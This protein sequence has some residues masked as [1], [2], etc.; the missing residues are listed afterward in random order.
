MPIESTADAVY[1]VICGCCIVSSCRHPAFIDACSYRFCVKFG[2]L[3][4][5]GSHQVWFLA[6]WP[7][8]MDLFKLRSVEGDVDAGQL[9]ASAISYDCCSEF[10]LDHA[11]A[12]S[13][14]LRVVF[15]FVI[16]YLQYKSVSLY[17]VTCPTIV[18]L[19]G[20]PSCNHGEASGFLTNFCFFV[21][22]L[23][24]ASL[25]LLLDR[26]AACICPKLS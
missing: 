1:S 17:V 25:T 6:Q 9:Y 5:L 26:V 2:S 15:L 4:S 22:I 21:N 10:V 18:V 12:T 13:L 24:C 16:V 19:S 14:S 20:T 11:A 8:P 7:G 3:T 23:A